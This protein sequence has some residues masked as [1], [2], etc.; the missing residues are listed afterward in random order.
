MSTDW[1]VP[2][3]ALPEALE[4]AHRFADA[5]DIPRAVSYG[6]AGNGHPHQNFIAHDA[7]E[8]KRIKA[9]VDETIREVSRSAARSR[10]STGLGKLKRHWLGIQLTPTAAARDACGEADARSR[11]ACSRRGT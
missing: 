10:R 4:A 7:D 2:Y 6:H 8:L 5:H 9:V 1:A 11:A 3:H